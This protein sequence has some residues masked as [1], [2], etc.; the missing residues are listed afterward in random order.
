MVSPETLDDVTLRE[1]MFKRAVDVVNEKYPVANEIYRAFLVDAHNVGGLLLYGM[2]Q[3]EQP[4][5]S[6]DYFA[7][8]QVG[9]Y[10][11]IARAVFD[12]FGC[13]FSYDHGPATVIKF[14]DGG[15]I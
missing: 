14:P 1:A 12:N 7:E 9:P 10:Q 4:T 15:L 13:R 2:S 3:A 11:D 5:L 6:Y 8:F